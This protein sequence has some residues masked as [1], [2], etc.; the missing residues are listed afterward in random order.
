MNKNRAFPLLLISFVISLLVNF[1][2]ASKPGPLVEEPLFS[3]SVADSLTYNSAGLTISVTAGSEEYIEFG[4]C[5]KAVVPTSGAKPTVADS[6]IVLSTSFESVSGHVKL[7]GLTPGTDYRAIVYIVYSDGRYEYS[8][9]TSSFKT[10]GLT[11]PTLNTSVISG[12]T[13]TTAIGGGSITSDGGV[14]ITARGI[15]WTTSGNNPTIAD[16]KTVD[17]SGIGSFTSNL[18]SLTAGV[19]Y[20]VVAYATNTRGTFYGTPMVFSSATVLPTLSTI[21]TTQITGTSAFLLGQLTSDGGSAI[22]ERGVCWS[23]TTGPTTSNSKLAY[24]TNT[25]SAYSINVTYLLPNTTYYYRAYASNGIGTA[26]GDEMS[27]KTLVI[28]PTVTT[29]AVIISGYATATTGGTFTFGG[30]LTSTGGESNLTKGVEWYIPNVFSADFKDVSGSSLF[31]WT[32]TNALLPAT[33]YSARAY[34]TNSAGTAYGAVV[35]FTTLTPTPELTTSSVVWVSG[36]SAIS[37]GNITNDRGVSITAKGVCWGTSSGPTIANNKTTDGSGT[38]EFTSGIMTGLLANSTYYV[39]AY[40]T[41]KYGTFYGNE[42]TFRNTPLTITTTAVSNLG[43]TTVTSGGNITTDGGSSVT[44]RGVCWSTSAGPTTAN[45]KLTDSS[46]GIGSYT[47]LITGLTTGTTYYLRAYAIN[48]S[49]T[50][51]GNEVTFKTTS[52][53]TL[54]TT[55]ASGVD[56]SS[57]TSGGNITNDGGATITSRGIC[58]SMSP[59]PTLLDLKTSDGSGS[60]IFSSTLTSLQIGGTYHIR[61]YAVNSVGTAYGNDITYV[62][63][64]SEGAVIMTEL[65]TSIMNTT[66][67]CG[68]IVFND[69]GFAITSRGVCWSTSPNPT[70]ANSKTV[71]GAGLGTFVSNMTGLSPNVTY[72]VRS[73]VVSSHGTTYGSEFSFTTHP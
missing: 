16:S 1:G 35:T 68:G 61:A 18:T 41:S 55:A 34:A 24:Q 9:S 52:L 30:K 17:G 26:Y 23:T 54:T 29:D 43:S 38:G 46:Q 14:P 3:I 45:S 8:Y 48:S 63:D 73:Y 59:N 4:V 7:T 51:Y 39:R 71:D 21:G 64:S 5:W 50:S 10:I 2:C 67:V 37:G 49:I 15:C 44:Q 72:H 27:F 31:S 28:L 65:V 12:I 70:T 66:A 13:A 47:S 60:G 25:V 11:D 6:H 20:K 57:A 40:A 32:N 33:T 22:T 58:W 56:M 42:V 19:S 69:G 62:V 53:A 36:T